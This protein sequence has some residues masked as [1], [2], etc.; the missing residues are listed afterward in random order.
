MIQ[1][2]LRHKTILPQALET[3]MRNRLSKQ[4]KEDWIK[5]LR[6]GEYQQGTG[7]L[8]QLKNGKETYCCLGVLADI[9]Y[10]GFWEAESKVES[11]GSN[12]KIEMSSTHYGAH[13]IGDHDVSELINMNDEGKTFE[14]IASWIEKYL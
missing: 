4:L 9:E 8:C 11:A 7:F 12:W 14:E 1:L 13:L 10:D 6:S 5:A 2:R 3:N